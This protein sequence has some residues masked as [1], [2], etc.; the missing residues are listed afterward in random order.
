[1]LNHPFQ[2]KPLKRANNMSQTEQSISYSWHRYPMEID[3][4]MY[5]LDI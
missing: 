4:V 5:L 3:G 2:V 1:V